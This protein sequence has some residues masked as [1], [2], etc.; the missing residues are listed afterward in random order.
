ML[1]G[2]CNSGTGSGGVWFFCSKSKP[3]LY[4]VK[5]VKFNCILIRNNFYSFDGVNR[6]IVP[7]QN[8]FQP[9]INVE[10]KPGIGFMIMEETFNK[11]MKTR[12]KITWGKGV[13]LLRFHWKIESKILGLDGWS[14][15]RQTSLYCVFCV[16]WFD[17]RWICMKIQMFSTSIT[18]RFCNNTNQMTLLRCNMWKLMGGR[19]YNTIYL[20][21]WTVIG[22]HIWRDQFKRMY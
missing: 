12:L 13:R 17:M 5:Q 18:K 9:K 2:C 4:Q 22:N 8:C 10:G 11:T 1:L 20:Y 16:C 7:C 19:M 6:S 3:P 21:C 14:Y 15:L